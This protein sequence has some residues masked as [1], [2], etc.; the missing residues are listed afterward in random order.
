MVDCDEGAR[1]K[2]QPTKLYLASQ[3]RATIAEQQHCQRNDDT[4]R[5][6]ARGYDNGNNG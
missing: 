6:V 1:V 3:E 5:C 4:L 2:Q